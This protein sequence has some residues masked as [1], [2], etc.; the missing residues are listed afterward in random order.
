MPGYFTSPEGDLEQIFVDDY[1]MIDQYAKTGSLWTWGR[2]SYGGLGDNTT[3]NRSNPVQTI[4]GGTNWKQVACGGYHTAAIKTDGT[5]WLWGHN[6]GRLGNNNGT[7]QSSP[8]QTVSQ[9]TNWKQVDGGGSNGTGGSLTSAGGAYGG[10]GGGG[11]QATN[12]SNGASGAVRIVWGPGLYNTGRQF[13]S[14]SV[15]AL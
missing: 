12:A 14:N 6:S 5:L 13:P 3:T 8:V 15:G 11:G 1:A 7:H 4:S 2:N 10:G 9:G